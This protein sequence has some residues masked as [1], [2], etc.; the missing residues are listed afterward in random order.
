MTSTTIPF[1]D[2]TRQYGSLRSEI[3]AAVLEV[4]RSGKY[5]LGPYVKRFE[6]EIAEYVGAEHAI[7]VASGTDALLLSLKALGIGSGDGVIVPS[8]TF[9][10][11]AG[12]VHNLGAIPIFADIDPRTFNIDPASVRDILESPYPNN[13]TNPTNSTN[14]TNPIDS[15]R[16]IIPVHLYGQP[17]DMNEIIAIAREYG[18]YVIEDAAQAIGATYRTTNPNQPNEP[19]KPNELPSG[20]IGHLGCFSFY[21]T[22]NLGGYGDGGMIV[23][24]DD[25][26]AERLRLLRVHGAKPKYYHRL[27]GT[28]SRLDAIQA[29]I[30][31]VKLKHLDDWSRARSELADRYDDALKGIEGVVTPYR[32]P[33]RSHIFHQ[34]TIRVLDDRRDELRDHLKKEGIGTMIYYPLPLHLQGCFAD[35]GYSEGD[36]PESERASREVLSLPIFPEL[37]NEEIDRLLESIRAFFA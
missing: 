26:L 8:F 1:L 25:G 13:P 11:T 33:G 24:S 16:A 29:A 35:L 22:K 36:L 32:A 3:D 34:Y 6:D 18:L 2:L 12:V 31:S 27:V 23:T 15:I 17:A 21:P 7:G 10:A 4:V 30:L 20:T 37:K 19:N 28:N 9:F 5:I 14:P